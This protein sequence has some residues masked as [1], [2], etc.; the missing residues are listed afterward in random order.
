[1]PR[2]PC[3]ATLEDMDRV[4][5]LLP[6]PMLTVVVEADGTGADEV[7]VHAGGQGVWVARMAAEMGAV[8]VLCGFAGG[9]TGRVP[10]GLLSDGPGERR[11]VPTAGTSGCYVMDRRGGERTLVALAQPPPPTRHEL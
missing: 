1:M 4:G 9:E 5:G 11:L 10:D 3:T 8:P 7:H 6:D 2:T